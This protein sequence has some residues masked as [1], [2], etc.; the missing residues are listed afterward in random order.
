LWLR[1]EWLWKEPLPDA[2]QALLTIDREAYARYLQ[3]RLQQP[4]L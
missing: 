3:E 1:V 4:D 2:T